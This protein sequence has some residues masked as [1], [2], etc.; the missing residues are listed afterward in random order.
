MLSTD[1]L[2]DA[3]SANLAKNVRDFLLRKGIPKRSQ[4]KKLK[5][6]LDLSL[7]QAHRKL[8]GSSNWDLT[9][10]RQ[11]ADYFGESLNSLNTIFTAPAFFPEKALTPATF[12]LEGRELP[13]LV[14]IGGP[15]HTI[16]NV[17]YVAL[18]TKNNEW[19]VIEAAVAHEKAIYHKV[20][21]LEISLK[22]AK[23]LLVAVLDDDEVSADNL[24]DF[25]H[26]MGFHAEA[27]YDAET[28]TQEIKERPFDAYVIDWLIGHTTAEP[29]IQLIR[30][31]ESRPVPIFLL[32]GEFT[33]GRVHEA[34]VARVLVEYDVSMQE[35]PTRLPIIA[36]ELSKALGVA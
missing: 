30:S 22:Q 17:D 11:V 18:K 20:K 13:C 16:K 29:L 32:T 8:N 36:A 35:K 9:Q 21:K 34:E 1:R 33:T 5:E 28:I 2:I 27:F 26:E 10:I 3:E 4:S 25:L 6:I 12:C 7:S 15:M 19:R 31:Q 14:S 23:Q 24:S